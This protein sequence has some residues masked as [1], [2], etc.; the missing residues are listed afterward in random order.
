MKPMGAMLPTQGPHKPH[1]ASHAT[2]PDQEQCSEKEMESQ[3]S[4]LVELWMGAPVRER[5][6]TM[7]H[8]L[9]SY[10]QHQS[11]GSQAG[12]WESKGTKRKG[13]L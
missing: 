13:L 6:G 2:K 12:L 3:E 11:S 8:A 9:A 10:P 1:K 7:H 5:L 4:C